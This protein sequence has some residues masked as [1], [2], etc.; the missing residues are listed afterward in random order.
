MGAKITARTIE[1]GSQTKGSAWFKSMFRSHFLGDRKLLSMSS[2]SHLEGSR[3]IVITVTQALFIRQWGY[4]RECNRGSTHH[5]GI[6]EQTYDNYMRTPRYHW[7][8]VTVCL[9]LLSRHY[10]RISNKKLTETKCRKWC[11]L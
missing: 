3:M 1:I 5:G 9:N 11:T 8:R 4:S 2:F 6:T 7:D 10:N